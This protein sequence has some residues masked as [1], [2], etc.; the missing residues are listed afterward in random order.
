MVYS[1]VVIDCRQQASTNWIGWIRARATRKEFCLKL[2]L[3]GQALSLHERVGVTS[4]VYGTSGPCLSGYFGR[5]DHSASYV[6][7]YSDD[8][9][10]VEKTF[11]TPPV[12]LY[13]EK[14]LTPHL[15]Q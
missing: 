12:N 2:G 14:R 3:M 15:K 6:I 11:A 9:E 7:W 13:N 4:V 8:C 10:M 5:I 1:L